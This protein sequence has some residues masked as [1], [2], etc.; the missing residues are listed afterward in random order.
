[1]GTRAKFMTL[2]RRV[3]HRRDRRTTVKDVPFRLRLAALFAALAL[4]GCASETPE[5]ASPGPGPGMDAGSPDVTMTSAAG[6]RPDGSQKPSCVALQSS[7]PIPARLSVMLASEPVTTRTVFVRDVFNL[8]N[9]TCGGCH[10]AGSYGGFHVDSV[11]F[12]IKVGQN[13]K[14]IERLTTDDI[15]KVMPPAPQG[16]PASQRSPDDPVSQLLVLVQAWVSAGGAG[17]GLAVFV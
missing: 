14:V 12:P 15:M 7:E 16:K 3:K 6:P 11:T 1:M 8:F 2:L 9:S 5:S 13:P 4:S 10:V 17:D